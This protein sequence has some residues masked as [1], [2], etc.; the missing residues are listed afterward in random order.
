MMSKWTLPYMINGIATH[1]TS[2]RYKH[3]IKLTRSMIIYE[4]LV[5]TMEKI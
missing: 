2:S 4:Q 1:H 3:E 5:C